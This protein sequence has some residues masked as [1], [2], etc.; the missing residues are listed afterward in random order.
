MTTKELNFD[1]FLHLS[2]YLDIDDL[3]SLKQVSKH[4]SEAVDYYLSRMRHLLIGSSV[5][6]YIDWCRQKNMRLEDQLRSTIHIKGE[7][8]ESQTID[9]LKSVSNNCKNISSVTLFECRIH[10]PLIQHFERF[11]KLNNWTVVDISMSPWT[12]KNDSQKIKE[13]LGRKIQV[14]TMNFIR[15]YPTVELT[16]IMKC[17]D[18]K[19]IPEYDWMFY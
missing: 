3:M 2:Q 4:S 8:Y 1:V 11:E 17:F 19:T 15:H 6:N 18:F 5:K 13:L 7:G 16:A 14:L 10:W 9:S 12:D